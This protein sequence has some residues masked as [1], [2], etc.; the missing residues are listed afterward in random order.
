MPP[1][2]PKH[3]GLRRVIG[4]LFK[5]KCSNADDATVPSDSEASERRTSRWSR[6]SRSHRQSLPDALLE[7]VTTTEPEAAVIQEITSPRAVG[8]DSNNATTNKIEMKKL[9]PKPK[10]SFAKGT[11]SPSGPLECESSD[12]SERE[13]SRLTF[14]FFGGSEADSTFCGTLRSSSLDKLHEQDI[15]PSLQAK[16]PLFLSVPLAKKMRRSGMLPDPTEYE[17]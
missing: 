10:L 16:M 17:L 12:E 8:Q 13:R 11:Q 14:L 1:S 4:G 9:K 5:R 15:H 7:L 2:K 6:W 3:R